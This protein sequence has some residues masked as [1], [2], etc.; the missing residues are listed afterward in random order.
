MCVCVSLCTCVGVMEGKLWHEVSGNSTVLYSHS[1]VQVGL[2]LV[3]HF[4]M[5][6]VIFTWNRN[7]ELA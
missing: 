7:G 3:T 1:Q 4:G 2:T 6:I 5:G